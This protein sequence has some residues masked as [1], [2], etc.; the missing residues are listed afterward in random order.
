[1]KENLELS[2]AHILGKR[3]LKVGVLSK[4][5]VIRIPECSKTHENLA[6]GWEKAHCAHN[7]AAN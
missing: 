6:V 7:D 4:K 5:K 3:H 1:M 2:K